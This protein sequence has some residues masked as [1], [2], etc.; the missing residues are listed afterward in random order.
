MLRVREHDP[1]DTV[2]PEQCDAVGGGGQGRD[3]L[4]IG[5]SAIMEES[6]L[7][8]GSRMYNKWT[9]KTP[10][11][12]ENAVTKIFQWMNAPTHRQLTAGVAH[13]KWDG[14]Q[15]VLLNRLQMR[16]T[17]RKG[18]PT[19]LTRSRTLRGYELL[20]RKGVHLVQ[21]LGERRCCWL[22]VPDDRCEEAAFSSKETG[23][24]ILRALI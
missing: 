5:H 8:K 4:S 14:C 18:S 22:E 9:W 1:L 21:E 15:L 16:L 24:A 19:P 23:L 7:Q 17:G 11:G 3:G 6:V 13:E 20:R 10:P 2:R 12:L